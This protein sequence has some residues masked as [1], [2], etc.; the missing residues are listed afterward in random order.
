MAA[1]NVISVIGTLVS[2]LGI[3]TSNIP[4]TPDKAKVQ[5]IIANDDPNGTGLSN[6]GGDLPDVRMWD[7]TA[8]FLGA[9][10]DG[11]NC[12]EGYTTCTS[13]VSTQEAV[14]YTLFSGNDDAIC[15]A[16]TGI[17]WAGGQKKYG[18]HPGNWAHGCDA[19]GYRGD[20]QKGNWSVLFPPSRAVYGTLGINNNLQ[21]LR[22]P[23]GPRHLQRG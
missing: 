15:I 8:E 4:E 13:E 20:K 9:N 6:A 23:K 19:G 14:T 17:S 12:E 1:A 5:Y 11:S 2:V 7:E 3:I 21:V 22:Q 18:F 16:W 10:Y